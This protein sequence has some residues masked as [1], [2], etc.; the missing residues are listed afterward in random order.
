LMLMFT[1]IWETH[2]HIAS[3]I[4][5]PLATEPWNTQ[6]AAHSASTAIHV[7][8]KPLIYHSPSQ[9]MPTPS[10]EAFSW[11]LELGCS[12]TFKIATG[13]LKLTSSSVSKLGFVQK[14]L[15][16]NAG[17]NGLRKLKHL[18][19]YTERWDVSVAIIDLVT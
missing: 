2:D 16:T 8:S 14:F 3:T 5:L 11:W 12:C 19:E 4:E 1:N 6:K 17:F 9:T 18:K 10:S 15:W 13:V 7:L